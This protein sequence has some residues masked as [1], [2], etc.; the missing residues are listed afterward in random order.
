MNNNLLHTIIYLFLSFF[1]MDCTQTQ[2]KTVKRT[3]KDG[4]RLWTQEEQDFLVKELNRN[5]LDIMREIQDLNAEQW[6]FKETKYR[7]SIAEIVEHLQVDDEL[8]YRELQVLTQLPEML[9]QGL[10]HSDDEKILRYADVNR[11]NR[12]EAPWYLVPRGRWCSKKDAINAYQRGRNYLIEFVRSTKKDFR[13]YITPTGNGQKDSGLRDLHQ[14]ML[15]SIAHTDRH[16]KQLQQ[17]KKHP[18]YPQQVIIE[19]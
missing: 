8:F 11:S 15:V 13:K 16:L 6:N 10:E 14:L 1:L 12:S 19:N 4:E 7:W 2:P 9:P 3:V 17:V 18:E 5:R